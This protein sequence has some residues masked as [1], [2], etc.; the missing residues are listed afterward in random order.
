MDITLC[1]ISGK[2]KN[3]EGVPTVLQYF[4]CQHQQSQCS[5]KSQIRIWFTYP[6]SKP[7]PC[8]CISLPY[9]IVILYLII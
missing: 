9:I 1:Y 4:Y 6:K 3:V 8:T 5:R 7:H 2:T